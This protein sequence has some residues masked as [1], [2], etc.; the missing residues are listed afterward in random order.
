MN[1]ILIMNLNKTL[2][3]PFYD[4][5]NF[6]F[7]DMTFSLFKIEIAII[8]QFSDYIDILIILKCRNQI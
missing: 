3:N 5:H 6:I 1:Y 2:E 7:T 8:H 4:I